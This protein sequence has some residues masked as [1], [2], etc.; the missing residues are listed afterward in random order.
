MGDP[1][2]AGAMGDDLDHAATA[3]DSQELPDLID[4]IDFWVGKALLDTN[5]DRRFALIRPEIE[6]YK[7]LRVCPPI[8]HHIK[9]LMN[10]ILTA[11][12]GVFE[13]THC[14]VCK[15]EI[16]VARNNKYPNRMIYCKNDYCKFLEQNG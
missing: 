11:N 13:N 1:N 14:G 16:L 2:A 12:S 15:K 9:R 5:F 6:L 8:E 3:V 7:T 4:K 10:L